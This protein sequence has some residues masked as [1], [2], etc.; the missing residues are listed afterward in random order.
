MAQTQFWITAPAELEGHS[1]K[2]SRSRDGPCSWQ[3][4]PLSITSASSSCL[5][6]RESLFGLPLREFP[7]TKEFPCSHW[8]V[9][10]CYGLFRILLTPV[11]ACPQ[12]H[13]GGQQPWSRLCFSFPVQSIG[14][15]PWSLRKWEAAG[16]EA[17]P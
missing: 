11:S 8:D 14:S 13:S 6:H 3:F 10:E 7:S 4:I 5:T 1:V 16:R 17:Q 12:P 2:A 9:C 15:D